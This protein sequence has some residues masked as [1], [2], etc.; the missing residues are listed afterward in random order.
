MT[1]AF[2][3]ITQHVITVMVE[4]KPG[5]L[6]AVASIFSEQGISIENLMTDEE[7]EATGLADLSGRE[8]KALNAWFAHS[9][10]EGSVS[11]AGPVRSPRQCIGPCPAIPRRVCVVIGPLSGWKSTSGGSGPP[12]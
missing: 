9:G 3:N 6:S 2:K 5:V 1:G 8:L 7:L 12:G 4:D 10:S 11:Q